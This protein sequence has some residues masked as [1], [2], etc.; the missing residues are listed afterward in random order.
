MEYYKFQKED[1]DRWLKNTTLETT[2]R[3]ST[4]KINT[5]YY[6][7]NQIGMKPYR[8][9]DHIMDKINKGFKRM[10]ITTP[11]Q[12]GKSAMIC[13]IAIWACDYNIFKDCLGSVTKIG[14]ISKTEKQSMKLIS[15]IRSMMV[16]G[17]RN[18]AKVTGGKYKNHF[19]AKID[20]SKNATNSKSQITFANGCEIISL[21]P[22]DAVRGYTFSMVFVD[23]AAFVEDDIFY[24]CIL[25][26]VRATD[27]YVILTSTPN[28]VSGYFYE[29]MDP[30]NKFDIN[31][32]YRFWLN[33]KDIDNETEIE[34]IDT[35]ITSLIERGKEKEALQEYKALFTAQTSAFFDYADVV[36]CFDTKL[37][38]KDTFII[39]CDCGVD[40]GMTNSHTVVTISYM[41]SNNQIERV[42]HR[43]YPFGTET[44]LIDDLR[45][46]KKKFNIQRFIPDNCAGGFLFIQQMVKEGWNVKPM[47]FKKDKVA[48]YFAFRNF[49]KNGKIKSYIDEELSIEM[50]TLQEEETQRS[51]RIAKPTNGTDDM[52]DSW[53]MSA[54]FYL[55]VENRGFNSYDLDEFA[56]F[57]DDYEY[58]DWNND[59]TSFQDINKLW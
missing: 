20:K 58:D 36:N 50:K 28:G 41:N 22:T 39:P 13:S 30:D 44:N 55:A 53:V 34:K 56:E 57:E 29:I 26:T 6:M 8:W 7:A 19:T 14:I 51:T 15:D 47:T 18:V 24:K 46:L 12:V 35:I 25:P 59:P 1:F 45:E 40:F 16:Q 33:Y 27:G 23:E 37:T 49:L 17:D 2:V 4:S 48:K 3:M 32:Y 38:K 21:P 31:E 42:Y 5:S 10:V 11:R 9:Q 54:Y 52:V 43:R